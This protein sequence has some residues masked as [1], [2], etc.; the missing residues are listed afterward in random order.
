MLADFGTQVQHEVTSR[1]TMTK[2][3]SP[4]NEQLQKISEMQVYQNIKVSIERNTEDIYLTSNS[5]MQRRGNK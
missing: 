2:P 4:T 1:E 5:E 3:F